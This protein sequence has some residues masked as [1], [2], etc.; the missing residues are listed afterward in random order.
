VSERTSSSTVLGAGSPNASARA[1]ALAA[2]ERGAK[3]VRVDHKLLA[4]V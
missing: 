1:L 2:A 3:V 4:V